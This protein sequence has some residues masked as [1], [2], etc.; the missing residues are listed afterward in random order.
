MSH[1][2][3]Q[4]LCSSFAVTWTLITELEVAW[5]AISYFVLPI[6]RIR[7]TNVLSSTDRMVAASALDVLTSTYAWL[8]TVA[9]LL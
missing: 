4:T 3:Q 7:R 8:G 6:A 5:T 2:V 1:S 9:Q